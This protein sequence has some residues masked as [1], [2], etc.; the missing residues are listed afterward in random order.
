MKNNAKNFISNCFNIKNSVSKRI[1][2]I[3]FLLIILLMTF[4]MIFLQY[5]FPSFYQAR[6]TTTLEKAILKFKTSYSMNIENNTTLFNSLE[7]FEIK[8]N[9][10][11]AIYS[12]S[13]NVKYIS[14]QDSENSTNM[15]LLNEI[16]KSLYNDK[17][18][19][20]ALLNS[21]KMLTKTFDNPKLSTKHI[22]CMTP[23]SL[24]T[25]ND[26]IIISISSFNN[27]E[28][29]SEVIEEFYK[30]IFIGIIILGFILS[31]IYSN[32]IS[33]PLTKINK[34]AK[35]MSAMNFSEKCTLKRTDEIGNLATT[36]N[37]LSENL[38]NAL[39]ELKEKNRKLELD[40]EKER[41]LDML[42]KD[43]IAGVSHELKTPIGIIEGY[44]EGLKDNIAEGE[45]RDMYLDVIIDEAH[46]MNSLVMDMLELSRLE[47]GKANLNLQSFDLKKLFEKVLFK[48]QVEINNNN[49]EV[50]SNYCDDNYYV[51]GDE[52]KIEQ[53]LTNFLSNAIKY[54][55]K[56]EKI[57]IDF[58]A[59]NDSLFFSIE[60]T[61]ANIP[62]KEITNI[63]N[64]FYKLDKARNR[65]SRSTGL[66]LSIVKNLLTL[67]N[68]QF[69]VMN[70]EKGV[71]FY[72][73]LKKAK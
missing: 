3:T 39:L 33:K 20:N 12:K 19:T 23:F 62:E 18:Y 21:N 48:N 35:K 6:K 8:N 25:E 7:N 11:I 45:A 32:L 70:T 63:W 4:A 13:G 15:N 57:I 41:Q 16:F 37:F 38:S 72:F 26:S 14:G 22:V 49:L 73:S 66:G 53:V 9:A 24:N 28:E 71:R 52:F 34:T 56:N 65:S 54:T 42:R 60:N 58:S 1:F 10:K 40:I 51:V 68:S 46:K 61:G 59:H 64:Q 31:L 50:I 43:F 27:I 30:Y 29:A 17:E 2:F 69:G 5:F 67:H 47:A 36:L 55:E 44:A